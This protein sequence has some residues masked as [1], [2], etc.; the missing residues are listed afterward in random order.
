MTV[1]HASVEIAASPADVWAVVAD[2][3]NL[4]RWDRRITGVDGVPNDGLG[5]GA[6]Y[7]VTMR[8]MGAR[9]TVPAKVIELRPREYS[10]IHLGGVVDATV[11]TW[12]EPLGATRTRLRHR[13]DYR[14]RGGPFG[15]L[16]A[17]AV[18]LLGAPV[19][20]RHGAQAQ[21]R[22]VEESLPGRPPD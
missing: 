22:Q 5:E 19:L 12:L 3:R 17:R 10:R 20:L 14:F 18:K 8:F 1:V 2:P 13:V 7:F 16:A 21:K 15:G 6:G 11:E 4:P 9:I